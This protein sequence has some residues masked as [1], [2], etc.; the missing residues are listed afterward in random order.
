[1]EPVLTQ[2]DHAIG[3]VQYALYRLDAEDSSLPTLAM[4]H[5]FLGSA[6]VFRPLLP[7]LRE[8][9]NP[10]L[11]DLA[12]HGHTKFPNDP[13]RYHGP[14]QT[15]DLA[16]L[17]KKECTEPP[18]LYGY[19]MGGRLALRYALHAPDQIRGL[20]LESTSPGIDGLNL[21]R[22]RLGKDQQRA[23]E[24]LADF[25]AFLK[26]WNR[27]PM[28]NGGS[29]TSEDLERYMDIQQNQD[30]VGVANSLLGFSPALVPS[31]SRQLQRLTMPV[32]LIAGGYDAT[33]AAYARSMEKAIPN[34]EAHI[35]P[36]AAHRIHLDAPREVGDIVTKFILTFA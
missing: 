23:S 31:V 34:A 5:G 33:Y 12:G 7:A 15:A 21:L 26:I 13:K 10:L 19:S 1:M 35:I 20:I 28:F 22:E 36:T 14:R 11:I 8:I 2:T 4:L 27:Q 16:A 9:C 18:F 6:E 25:G 29:P 32:A 3:D 30:P 24:I 17:L